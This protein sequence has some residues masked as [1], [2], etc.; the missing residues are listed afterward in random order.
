M[1]S[2]AASDEG[3]TDPDEDVLTRLALAP[4]LATRRAARLPPPRRRRPNRRPCCWGLSPVVVV[5]VVVVMVVVVM[6]AACDRGAFAPGARVPMT[7]SIGY[8]PNRLRC[9]AFAP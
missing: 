6:V 1:P 2:A 5:V 8:A 3:V 7:T 4:A 9:Q